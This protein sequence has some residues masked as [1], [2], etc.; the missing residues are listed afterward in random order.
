MTN[1]DL[2]LPYPIDG[3]TPTI[4]RL[5]NYIY[6]ANKS[7]LPM[8]AVSALAGC[9]LATQG[10]IKV[11]WR[12]A[13]PSPVGMIFIVEA[14]SG[15]RKTANDQIALHEHRA[16]DKRQSE[17]EAEDAKAHARKKAVWDSKRKALLRSIGQGAAKD[18]DTSQLEKLLED[19]EKLPP[20][21]RK[22]PRMLISDITAPAVARHLRET[23]RYAGLVSD[24]GG[25][26]LSSGALS[27]P[28][29]INSIWDS[30]DG[31]TDRMGRGRTEV[32]GASLTVYLQV[33]PGVLE[34]FLNRQGQLT[35]ASGNSSRWLYTNPPS[36]QGTRFISPYIDPYLD[37]AESYHLR[38]RQLLVEYDRD[39]FPP[40]KIK[41]FSGAAQQYL[42]WFSNQIETELAENGR[43]YFMRGAAAKAAE[44]CA[45]LAAIM[46]EF[47]GD[48]GKIDAPVVV[49]A[50]KVVAWHL[51]QYRM[52]FAPLTQMEQDILDLEE[53]IF[54]HHHHWMKTNGQVKGAELARY[55]P[56]RLRQ[57]DKLLSIVLELA[58]LG[59][60]QVWDESGGSWSV[61]LRYWIPNHTPAPSA[62]E[63]QTGVR[64]LYHP[65]RDRMLR[66]VAQAKA[67][68][69]HPQDGGDKY[70]LWPGCAL[71]QS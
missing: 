22:R 33:Q 27:N 60:L 44:N 55:A 8:C 20:I 46:H 43:F 25:V 3:L 34:Y 11:K 57:V 36:K 52:R 53:S 7:P 14:L 32:Y 69:G 4:Q 50:I 51:N 39:G 45:R 56:K 24:E 61:N 64:F 63:L 26:I 35:H 2:D 18:A 58:I 65:Q 9:T 16:F 42:N 6:A 67:A 10:L 31:V 5:A 48:S 29:M 38:I 30:G 59:R 62:E 15:E 17:R 37:T 28:A 41:E 1:S 40:Q 71:P 21:Q 12:D 70:W 13:P 68:N 47:E 49:G 66:R 54:K 23:Y 19:H